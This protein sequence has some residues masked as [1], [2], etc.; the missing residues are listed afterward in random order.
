MGGYVYAQVGIGAVG[1]GKGVVG[2]SLDKGIVFQFINLAAGLVAPVAEK[3]NVSIFSYD[4]YC[5]FFGFLEHF[6][7]QA[8]FING[9]RDGD[10]IGGRLD[11]GIYDT[12]VVPSFVVGCENE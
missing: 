7:G 3:L 8:L 12:A 5:A 4:R 1:Y 6:T 2:G 11:C 10:G 9:Q